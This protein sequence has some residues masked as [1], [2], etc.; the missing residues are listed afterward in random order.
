MG[1]PEAAAPATLAPA[2]TLLQEGAMTST[3]IFALSLLAAAPQGAD[4]SARAPPPAVPPPAAAASQAPLEASVWY[5]QPAAILDAAAISI[6]GTGVF[7]V[8]R[9]SGGETS[10]LAG[11]LI[12]GGLGGFAFGAPVLHLKNEHPGRAA[13]S[14]A[15]R[16]L[17]GYASLYLLVSHD[18]GVCNGANGTDHPGCD[19]LSFAQLAAMSVPILVA[20]ALDDLVLARGTIPVPASKAAPGTWI[21]PSAGPG[22]LSLSVGGAF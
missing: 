22:S 20:A 1:V 12:I 6:L 14:L 8:G 2:P 9:G 16:L 15:L 21:A 10:G 7:L 17:A 4:A 13:A 3:V 19:K 18:A 5:G 11:P